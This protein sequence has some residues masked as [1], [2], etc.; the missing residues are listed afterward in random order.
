MGLMIER[1]MRDPWELQAVRRLDALKYDGIEYYRVEHPET[2]VNRELEQAAE[3][4]L[5]VEQFVRSWEAMDKGH[6]ARPKRDG[7]DRVAMRDVRRARYLRIWS[8][9]HCAIA[10]DG[11]PTVF[12]A[13]TSGALLRALGRVRIPARLLEPLEAFDAAYASAGIWWA[14]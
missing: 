3:L 1:V 10:T 11:V 13:H 2:L 12:A 9:F 7:L 8:G 4:S 6:P 5:L 14:V